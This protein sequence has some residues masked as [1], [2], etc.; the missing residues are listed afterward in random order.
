MPE[1]FIKNACSPSGPGALR[2]PILKTTFLTS[3]A[4]NGAVNIS[5][6]S[7]VTLGITFSI[8]AG[9]IAGLSVENR[10]VK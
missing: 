2:S 8:N 6:I 5:F 10:L 4:E 3:S 1:L 7:G 9:T